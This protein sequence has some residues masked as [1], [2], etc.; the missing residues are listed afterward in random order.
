LLTEFRLESRGQERQEEQTMEAAHRPLRV[1]ASASST[2]T[3]FAGGSGFEW[4]YSLLASVLMGGVF[5]DGW[6]H[7]HGRVDQSFFTPWHAVLYSGFAILAAF[8]VLTLVRNH[9]SGL[10]WSSAF[11]P[12]YGAAVVGAAVFAVGGVGDLIWHSLF[13]IEQGIEGNISPS[14]LTLALGGLMLFIGPLRSAWRKTGPNAAA[15]WVTLLPAVLASTYIYSMLTYFTQYASPIVT[16]RAN[17][18]ITQIL[19]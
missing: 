12:G 10:P 2:G 14:H 17:L 11:P 9:A 19:I 7:N 15:R 18:H 16:S 5:L 1:E 4:V 3:W 8:L 6:A 13:G